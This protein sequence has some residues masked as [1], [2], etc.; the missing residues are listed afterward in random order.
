M[1]RCPKGLYLLFYVTNLQKTSKQKLAG[2]AAKCDKNS[3]NFV[4]NRKFLQKK[5]ASNE[6]Y[7]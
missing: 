1:S 4:S 2:N 6:V 5:S 3:E 7:K